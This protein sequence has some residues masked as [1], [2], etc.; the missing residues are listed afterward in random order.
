MAANIVDIK[1]VDITK[2][3]KDKV[4]AIDTNVLVWTYYSKAS[5][6]ALHTPLY[7]V[8][9]Y[10]DFMAKLIENGNKLVTTNLNITELLGIIE[11]SEYKIYKVINNYSS[12][13]FK[14]FRALTSERLNYKSEIDTILLQL[15]ATFNGSIEIV[16]VT[17]E[18]IEAFKQ[19][20]GGNKCD[21]FD[22]IVIEH[23]KEKGIINY[24]SDD[25]D[26]STIDGITLY[27][28]YTI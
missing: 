19:D 21:V 25:K 22:Y 17:I 7:Q 9:D 12:L 24:V 20:I 6:L 26:F 2:I 28:S 14:D 1:D 13:K 5:D 18:K 23:L 3:P 15:N 11:R 27:T 10:P 8:V 16:D 4:F